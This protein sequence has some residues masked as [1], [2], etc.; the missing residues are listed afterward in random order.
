MSDTPQQPYDPYNQQPTGAPQ[1]SGY[2][3]PQGYQQPYAQVGP[4]GTKSKLAAG[5][6]GIF[7]G[8]LGVHNF[9]LGYTGKAVTQLLIT[10]LSLGVLSAISAIW[11]LVEGILIIASQ[12]GTQWHKDA[13][14]FELQD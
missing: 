8:S 2:Q 9:Y 6:F 3:T 4:V 10:V 7:L 13:Q 12:P 11:G 1:S 5:L 14:G